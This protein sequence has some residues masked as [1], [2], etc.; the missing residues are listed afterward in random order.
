MRAT[1]SQSA[2]P[3]AACGQKQGPG[4]RPGVE[5]VRLRVG[6]M[7]G[8][9][10]PV[11]LIDLEGALGVEKGRIEPRPHVEQC[12]A[13]ALMPVARPTVFSEGS[14][15]RLTHSER[16]RDLPAYSGAGGPTPQLRRAR[17]TVERQPCGREY[18]RDCSRTGHNQADGGGQ[19]DTGWTVVGGK[20][21][22]QAMFSL[23][24]GTFEKGGF[25]L[26]IRRAGS[27]PWRP[28]A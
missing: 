9:V 15:A 21:P 12:S 24:R 11:A 8:E 13:F 22:G 5:Q 26:L 2:G 27:K 20:C 25:R 23:V 19:N 6:S 14:Q 16:R 28:T 3:S 1:S 7:F 18:S 4:I 17:S 10:G